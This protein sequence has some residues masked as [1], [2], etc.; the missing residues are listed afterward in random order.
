ME[1]LSGGER[2]TALCGAQTC[3]PCPGLAEELFTVHGFIFFA[4]ISWFVLSL[5]AC[6]CACACGTWWWVQPLSGVWTHGRKRAYPGP[7]APPARRLVIGRV[8]ER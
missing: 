1:I 6:C 8:D 4:L 3:P 7:E 2:I 5:G